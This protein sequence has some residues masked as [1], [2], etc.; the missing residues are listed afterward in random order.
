MT[1]SFLAASFVPEEEKC[2]MLIITCLLSCPEVSNESD[3]DGG[4]KR[5]H[6]SGGIIYFL[7]IYLR[8]FVSLRACYSF[9]STAFIF[10]VCLLQ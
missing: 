4:E 1:H 8:A 3:K 7:S 9:L 2:L 5:R 6:P 10:H